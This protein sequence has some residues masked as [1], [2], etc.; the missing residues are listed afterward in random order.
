M[1]RA[2]STLTVLLATAVM[3]LAAQETSAAAAPNKVAGFNRVKISGRPALG[4]YAGSLMK[5]QGQA[6]RKGQTEPD[7]GASLFWSSDN[8]D[9]AWVAEDGTVVLLRPGRAKITVSFG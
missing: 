1:R 2:V 9:V 4:L 8:L 6:I 5:L 7:A 3:P